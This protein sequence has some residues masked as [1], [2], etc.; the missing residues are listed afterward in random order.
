M[1]SLEFETTAMASASTD[2]TNAHADLQTLQT[3]MS[4][5]QQDLAG[6]WLGNASST[7]ASVYLEFQD[8]YAKMNQGLNGLGQNLAT[9]RSTLG[10]SDTNVQ[11]TAKHVGGLING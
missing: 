6:G 10:T 3:A 4:N 11:S 1:P 9:A 5:I 2:I 8:A 7:F